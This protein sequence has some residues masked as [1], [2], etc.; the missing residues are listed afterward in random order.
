MSLYNVA[1]PLIM[2]LDMKLGERLSSVQREMV[3]CFCHASL[4]HTREAINC[5]SDKF[6]LS[7]PSFIGHTMIDSYDKRVIS[8]Y[9][10]MLED[11]TLRN[12]EGSLYTLLLSH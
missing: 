10:S 2:H 5:F 12:N 11:F 7:F 1:A 6:S 4:L 8:F 3:L 9:S